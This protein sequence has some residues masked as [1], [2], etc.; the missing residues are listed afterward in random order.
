M[1]VLA[2]FPENDWHWLKA[3]QTSMQRRSAP[4]RNKRERLVPADQLM[5]LGLDLTEAAK[6]TLDQLSESDVN[7]RRLVAA[8]RDYR[9]GLTIALLALRPLRVK[10]LLAI[11]IDQHLRQS[12]GRPTLH[13]TASETKNGRSL[14]A[15]WPESLQPALTHYLQKVRPRLIAAKAPIDPAHLSRP[16]GAK[17]WVAQGGT[18][19]TAGGLYKALGRHTR[20]RFGHAINAHLFRDCV[21]STMANQDPNHARYA[22]Q[23]LGHRNLYS[24]EQS[25]I[26]ADS[27]IAL[28]QHHDLISAM[29]GDTRQ[30]RRVVATKDAERLAGERLATAEAGLAVLARTQPRHRA[31]LDRQR[32]PPGDAPNA[33]PRLGV[34]G[35]PREPS[36]QF[37]SSQQL[38]FLSEDS[39]NGGSIGLGDN[40]HPDSMVAR[41]TVGKRKGG[42]TLN[43]S[44]GN[45]AAREFVS[46]R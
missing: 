42:A 24:T 36:A 20:R 3:V 22:A 1:V 31:R 25:Y 11:E 46:P 32:R 4:S 35:N 13:F 44:D 30:R 28:H 18:P 38:S 10:N 27:R 7:A 40:E 33:F 9:D 12:G 23:L 37:D 41:T 29:R 26:H 8:A 17:L 19:L 21:A 16:L 14:D 34:V 5:Q 45:T 6:Q 15:V 43:S 2:I 39:A